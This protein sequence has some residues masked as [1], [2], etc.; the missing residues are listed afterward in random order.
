MPHLSSAHHETSKYD[1]PIEQDKGSRTS[2]ISWIRI[3]TSQS[4]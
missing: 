2:K 1:Y 4:Q 3:Q